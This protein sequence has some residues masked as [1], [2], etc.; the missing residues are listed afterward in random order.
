MSVECFVIAFGFSLQ[1][2]HHCESGS[3]TTLI[4]IKAIIF[5]LIAIKAFI[6]IKWQMCLVGRNSREFNG[7]GI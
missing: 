2:N 6:F 7:I 4:G 1:S 5:C 3:W